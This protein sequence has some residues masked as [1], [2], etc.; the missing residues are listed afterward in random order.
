MEHNLEVY[1]NGRIESR[2]LKYTIP[3][4]NA[5]TQDYDGNLQLGSI[6]VGDYH[7]APGNMIMDDLVI[8]E[9]ELSCDDAFRLYLAYNWVGSNL[10]AGQ[11]YSL[12]Y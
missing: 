7:W 11:K 10:L 9:Q 2:L 4:N 12:V 6:S 3:W 5:N 1:I 8:W